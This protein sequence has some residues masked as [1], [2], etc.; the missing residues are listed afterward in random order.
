MP[1]NPFENALAQLREAAQVAGLDP[2]ILIRLEHHDRIVEVMGRSNRSHLIKIEK[3]EHVP[4]ADLRD[5][6]ADATNVPREFFHDEEDALRAPFREQDGSRSSRSRAA[7]H[8]RR[9]G[10]GRRE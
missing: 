6:Y 10:G 3:G 9:A 7:N 4:R 8:P 5:A 2:D 1:N